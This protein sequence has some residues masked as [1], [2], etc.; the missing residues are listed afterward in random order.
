MSREGM[1][2]DRRVCYTWSENMSTLIPGTQTIRQSWTEK[3]EIVFSVWNIVLRHHAVLP[4]Q[5][6]QT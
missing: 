5:N 2:N 3:T 1:H 4:L 6:K